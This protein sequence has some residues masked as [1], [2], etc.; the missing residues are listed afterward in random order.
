M[1]YRIVRLTDPERLT[2]S[3]GAARPITTTAL[4]AGVLLEHV[5]PITQAA[6]TAAVATRLRALPSNVFV[7]P[8]VQRDV[9]GAVNDAFANLLR[10]G[11]LRRDGEG[12]ALTDRRADLRF[13]HIADM[14]TY[15]RT[16]LEET[17]ACAERL[18]ASG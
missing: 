7:D 6:A 18:L 9:A 3:L 8:E 12:F 1:L 4:L 14:L 11:T 10:R 16:M 17:L 15:Q 2:E 13:P 5:A